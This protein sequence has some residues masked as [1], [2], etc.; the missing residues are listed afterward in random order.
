M[1]RLIAT[2]AYHLTM[3][4]LIEPQHALESETYILYARSG[5]PQVVADLSIVLKE[6]AAW[7]LDLDEVEQAAAYWHSM[8]VPF[9]QAAWKKLAAVVMHSGLPLSVRGVADGEVVLPGD[10]IAV[11]TAPA[12]LAAVIE[13]WLIGRMMKS[14]Q[15]ATRFTKVAQA[16]G[17]EYERV[18]EVGLRASPSVAEHIDTVRVLSRVGLQMSSAGSAALEN[19]IAA[20]GSMGHRYTQRFASDY[21]AFEA[22]LQ[23][24]CRYRR[25]QR[26]NR[27]L[28]LSLLLD[29]R[30]TL[31]SGLPAALRLIKKHRAA[32]REQVSLSLRLDSGD[33]V[34]QLQ[35]V[36][37]AIKRE[38]VDPELWPTVII[39]SGLNAT[40]IAAL[41]QVVAGLDYPRAKC[42]YGVGGYLTGKVDRDA[43]GLVYK[44][45]SVAGRPVM[46]FADAP[47]AAKQSYPGEVTLFE[48][49]YEHH[50]RRL[51]AQRSEVDALLRRGWHECFQPLLVDG[52]STGAVPSAAQVQERIRRRWPQVAR[53]YVGD[54]RFPVGIAL[55]PLLSVATRRL[56]AGLKRR[57]LQGGRCR[58][59]A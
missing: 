19:G 46:K 2:D 57:Q 25:E 31:A 32:V 44:L 22:A 49:S 30:D 1:N 33:L 45:S 23:R 24:L 21:E 10:P 38:L 5:G 43:I 15:L 9:A 27:R 47:G 55:R 37:S 8:Q 16:L 41:E 18:F 56:V 51:V 52:H 35:Q 53:A 42:V 39:E 50:V 12:L 13:P 29:T 14:L 54:E 28:P 34:F 7:K 6:L 59:C 4:Y 26:I 17:W 36:L 58:V 40:R 20:G 11:F 3:G 48:R